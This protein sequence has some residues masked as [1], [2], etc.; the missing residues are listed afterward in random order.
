ML[1]ISNDYTMLSKFIL[2]MVT[3]FNLGHNSI[4]SL[5]PR[6][7]DPKT[8]ANRPNPTPQPPVLSIKTRSPFPQWFYP[9]RTAKHCN[10]LVDIIL[11]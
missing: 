7:N 4:K 11:P 8:Q 6:T 9:K 1:C 10:D 5:N 2:S 3:T